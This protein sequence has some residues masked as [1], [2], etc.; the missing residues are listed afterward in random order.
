M[1]VSPTAR[2]AGYNLDIEVGAVDPNSRFFIDEFA[3]ALHG[4]GATLSADIGNWSA[5]AMR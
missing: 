4:H 2:Y 5:Q 1:T 3:A